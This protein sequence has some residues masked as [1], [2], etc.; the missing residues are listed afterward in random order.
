MES[1]KQCLM[2]RDELT[3]E[4][5]DEIIADALENA[6]CRLEDNESLEGILE[7]YFGLEDDFLPEFLD[8][9]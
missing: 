5:A 7:E 6:R 8:M 9:I 2:N 1:I 3:G 4:E